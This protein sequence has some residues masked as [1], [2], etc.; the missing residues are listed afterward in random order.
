[1]RV[2]YSH[3][4]RSADGQWVHIDALTSALKARG[5]DIIMAG[6]DVG[7]NRSLNADNNRGMAQLLPAPLYELA[8]FAYS[9]PGYVRLARLAANERPDALYERYN[10]HYLAGTWLSRRLKLPFVL[11]VNAPLAEERTAYGN[12][13]LKSFAQKNEAS[14]WRAA[15]MVLPVTN[16]LAQ[17]V[18]AAGI[19]D[20]RIEVIQNGVDDR[21]LAPVDPQKARARYGLDGKLVLGFS[22]FVRDWHG[23]D[24]AV[25]Y[26]A[27]AGRDDLHLLVVGD[28]P[29]RAGLETLARELGVAQHVTF[30]GVVQR[31][32]MP[33]HVAAFDIG[34]QPA[35]VEYASP[36][37]LFEYMALGKA[38]LAPDA[39]NILEVLKD[40]ENGLLFRGEGF[41]A[42]LNVLVNDK[43]I[44][45]Q[46]GAAAREMIL[47][48]G[49]T[50]SENARRVEQIL[51]RLARDAK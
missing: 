48:E 29:A 27:R 19:P 40:G 14:V 45:D 44:R 8:E 50:W 41:D 17:H 22:G 36:L 35:V 3:R 37:K 38:V 34:L 24:R 11:E 9:A 6:P 18:R 49:Y 13:A 33:E 1:M 39:P 15:D 30:T 16:A 43:T 32:A 2:L 51:A 46:M 31:D 10:L 20:E 26:L 5:H 12:L 4:T 7:E 23:V 25:R 21:F 28:G 47:R 42:A